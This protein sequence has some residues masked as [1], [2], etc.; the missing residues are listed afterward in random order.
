MRKVH[1]YDL[2]DTDLDQLKRP[3]LAGQETC[4]VDT[5]VLDHHV[6]LKQTYESKQLVQVFETPPGKCSSVMSD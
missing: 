2:P 3:S 6:L 1:L 5:L 4:H